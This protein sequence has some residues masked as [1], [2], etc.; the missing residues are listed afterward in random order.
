MIHWLEQIKPKEINLVGNKA[1]ALKLLLQEE[2]PVISG[3]VIGSNI[4]REFLEMI[5]QDPLSAVFVPSSLHLNFDEHKVLQ[6]VSTQLCQQLLSFPLPEEWENNIFAAAKN[7]NSSHLI[8]RASFSF[9]DDVEADF[10]G[11]MSSVVCPCH[12]PSL[13]SAVK[14]VWANLSRAKCLL[15]CQRLNIPIELVNLA[16]LIQPITKAIASGNLELNGGQFQVNS[17]WGLGH[18]LVKG[19][20]FPDSYLFEKL[21]VKEKTLG[22]KMLATG[23]SEQGT[24]ENYLLSE[25]QQEQYSL[26]NDDL[27]QLARLAENLLIY[28]PKINLIEWTILSTPQGKQIYITQAN[29]F[30]LME[31]QEFLPPIL[32]GLPASSGKAIANVQI[33]GGANKHIQN[34]PQGCII[35]IKM[36]SPDWLPLLKKASGVITEVGGMTSHGAIIARELKIPAIVGVTNATKILKPGESVLVNGHTGEIFINQ[37][38][39]KIIL[40]AKPILPKQLSMMNHPI[41]TKLMVNVSQSNSL[42]S[43]ATLPV[44]GVGL[45]RGEFMLLDLLHE[46]SI[47]NWS[48]SSQKVLLRQ[49]LINSLTKFAAAFAP[50]P[51]FYRSTDYSQFP[52]V[53][54][55]NPQEKGTYNYLRNPSLFELELQA[56]HQVNS[57]GDGNVNL[58]LP[59]VRSV[60]E[61]I[62][63][64]EKVVQA[65]LT[66]N[67]SFQL[68]IMAEVPSVIFLLSA[69]VKA[70]VQG[71]AIGTN[72]LTE[73]ILGVSRH[74][75]LPGLNITHPAML[76]A[77]KQLI[78]GAKNLEIPVSICG[79]AT[80]DYPQ[81]IEHLVKW[82]VDCI[83]VEPDA[84][85]KIYQAIARAETRLLLKSAHP[86]SN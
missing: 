67:A 12:K 74:V 85:E 71:I 33:I 58:I 66:Q 38:P 32:K 64:R 52:L 54:G 41:G 84:V 76:E 30:S 47:S 24:L 6:N 83:S 80:T 48:E 53:S 35:V 10:S 31:P 9:P 77:I 44:D 17:T 29:L 13:S 51:V 68:W 63:C 3:F 43:S 16:V 5:N 25:Q 42:D 79:Q 18:S 46:N 56:L 81:I 75:S 55:Q 7:L 62:F 11:L 57:Q 73:L 50:R 2:Y 15:Y 60:Q 59:F 1:F 61:F 14:Q 72:D 69:Y 78:Q 39:E 21:I 70:G 20:V 4:Y 82:G 22:N 28:R 8:V 65:G 19:Q 34:I 27:E 23:L 36:V 49:Q 86:V 40:D 45:L 26:E 37:K